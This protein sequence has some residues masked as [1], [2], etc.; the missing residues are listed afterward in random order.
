MPS[1]LIKRAK[2]S[3]SQSLLALLKI[4]LLPNDTTAAND[5]LVFS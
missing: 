5:K 1:S 2:M 4:F 3:Q